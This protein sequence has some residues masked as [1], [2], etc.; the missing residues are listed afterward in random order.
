[1]TKFIRD[2]ELEFRDWMVFLF[3]IMIFGS[4]LLVFLYEER[5]GIQPKQ[6]LVGTVIYRNRVAQRKNSSTVIWDNVAQRENVYN[7]D[8]IRTDDLA[9]AII[10]LENGTQIELDPFSMIV[11]NISDDE[12]KIVLDRGSVIVRPSENSK[13]Q[14]IRGNRIHFNIKG[15]LRIFGQD[16]NRYVVLSDKGFSMVEG[17]IDS[18]QSSEINKFQSEDIL[19]IPGDTIVKINSRA[20]ERIKN[21][22]EIIYPTD[23]TRY[24]VDGK[25]ELEVRFHW[26]ADVAV[27]KILIAKDPF[28]QNLIV[29]KQVNQDKFR[30]NLTD[31]NYY[32]KVLG[33]D[34]ESSPARFKIKS[35]EDIKTIEPIPNEK[36]FLD[37]GDLTAFLWSESE[38]AESY[39]LEIASDSGFQNT[40]KKMVT[41][42]PGLSVSMPEGKYFWRVVSVGSLAGTDYNSNISEFE[43]VRPIEN[44]SI[45]EENKIIE[46]IPNNDLP[47]SEISSDNQDS[48][49]T[50]KEAKVKDEKNN[51][52]ESTIKRDSEESVTVLNKPIPI[53]PLSSVDMAG[54]ER[55]VFRWKHTPGAEY[56]EFIFRNETGIGQELLRK[57]V[58]SNQFIIGDLSILDIGNF[59]WEVIA[60]GKNSL[61]ASTG[62]I[63]IKILLSDE[64]D[65]PDLEIR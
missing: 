61:A 57:K 41:H 17:D 23:N 6:K 31:G 4:A 5:P 20:I 29:E 33:A 44:L 1:M 39:R 49:K 40:I 60:Y 27:E 47:Q 28:F 11:L 24:F 3:S 46:E 22:I 9:E 58:D 13:V 21:S 19:D 25:L 34:S 30:I 2:L 59:S 65:A 38:L 32:W 54:K 15:L 42:R 63:N 12:S 14:L 55:L 62:K 10:I 35:R 43:I 51:N 56:Y 7:F 45:V 16:E 37:P 8:S 36:L 50:A 52:L 18:I 53:Y 26:K 48:K 64:P